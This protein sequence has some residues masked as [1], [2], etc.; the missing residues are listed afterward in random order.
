M[1][2]Q[3]RSSF[4]ELI[5]NYEPGKPL[6]IL[7]AV[8]VEP[9]IH[10]VQYTDLHAKAEEV[11]YDETRVEEVIEKERQQLATLIPVEGRPAQIGDVAVLDFKGV[12]AKTEGEDESANRH[13][14]PEAKQQAFKWSYKKINS[15]RDL[16]LA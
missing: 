7:A 1:N 6:T 2:S 14:F 13:Q 9:E 11:K 15:F 3:L 16:F 4:D 5:T 10:L 8:D 12:L